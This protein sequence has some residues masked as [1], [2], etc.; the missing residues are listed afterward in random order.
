EGG[1]GCLFCDKNRDLRSF[2]HV[3][4]L[5][6]LHHLKL[7]EI[8]ADR[9]PLGREK[10]HPLALTIERIAAKL[11]ALKALSSE[12]AEWVVE[13]RFRVQEGRYHQFYT[14]AFNILEGG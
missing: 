8:N 11:D 13:A 12:C 2:D 1:A 5:A 6:S 10:D 3:W 7:A 4:N 14:A 9:T